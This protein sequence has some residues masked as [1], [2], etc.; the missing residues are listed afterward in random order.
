MNCKQ[1][2]W[3]KVQVELHEHNLCIFISCSL[4]A[5]QTC[6]FIHKFIFILDPNHMNGLLKLLKKKNTQNS[7]FPMFVFLWIKLH[8]HELQTMNVNKIL[9]ITNNEH[10][11]MYFLFHVHGLQFKLVTLFTKFIFILDPKQRRS[12]WEVFFFSKLS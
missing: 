11:F 8:V 5:I 4:F 2:T 6:N 9:W 12:L 7:Y 3:I 10:V 1:W